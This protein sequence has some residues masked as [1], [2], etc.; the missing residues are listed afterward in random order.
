[1][2]LQRT[3]RGTTFKVF[4]DSGISYLQKPIVPDV[5]ARRVRE[6]LDMPFVGPV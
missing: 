4:L 3:G 1:L 2:G 5:L 6:V